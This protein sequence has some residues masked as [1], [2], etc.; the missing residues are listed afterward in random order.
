MEKYKVFLDVVETK[1]FTNTAINFSYS[2][3][4]VSQM[5]QKLESD[6]NFQ[7]FHRN[8][9]ELKLT[10]DGESILPY[11]QSLV[12][13][14]NEMENTTKTISKGLDGFVKIG[15]IS[16][17]C[18]KFLP[19]VIK[20]FSEEYPKINIEII[21]NKNKV[22]KEMIRE[23]SI[24]FGILSLNDSKGFEKTFLLQDEICA[25]IP[26]NSPLAKKKSVSILDLANDP[27][28]LLTDSNH[29][30]FLKLFY[31]AQVNPYIKYRVSDEYTILS[32]IEEGLGITLLPESFFIKSQYNVVIK[33]LNPSVYREIGIIYNSEELLSESSKVLI[34][35]LTNNLNKN[36]PR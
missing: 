3:S 9:K 21:H 1:S 23:N 7:L 6:F 8:R 12:K 31:D 11:I 5:I 20:S 32:M 22:I 34:E 35:N 17:V 2:Q 18:C 14:Y 10:N 28:I 13:A 36:I 26:T 27:Y 19:K 24:D 29:Y 33:K 25:I 16:S 15:A 30:D 4:A